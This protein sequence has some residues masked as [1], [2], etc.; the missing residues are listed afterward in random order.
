MKSHELLNK[1]RFNP[2]PTCH[3]DMKELYD[4][5]TTHL[6]ELKKCDH[7]LLGSLFAIIS[8]E[9]IGCRDAPRFAYICLTADIRYNKNE[10]R[11]IIERL[12]LVMK[13]GIGLLEEKSYLFSIEV[14]MVIDFAIMADVLRLNKAGFYTTEDWWRNALEG[15]NTAQRKYPSYTDDL[16]ISLGQKYHET[17]ADGVYTYLLNI[18]S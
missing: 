16:I 8:Y 7:Y 2:I 3:K 18:Y 6:V 5:C 10:T 15:L 9:K 12:Q 17:V 11:S 4:Y 1:L 14:E 13:G